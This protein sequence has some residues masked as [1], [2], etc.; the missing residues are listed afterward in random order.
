MTARVSSQGVPW[1]GNTDCVAHKD[2]VEGTSYEVLHQC[3]VSTIDFCCNLPLEM[4]A[5]FHTSC[6]VLLD[7]NSIVF[8]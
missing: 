1:T 4:A 6:Q 8:P 2:S 7:L 5:S 3:F